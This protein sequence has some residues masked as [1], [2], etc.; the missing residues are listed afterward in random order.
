[1]IGG[2][3]KTQQGLENAMQVGRFEKIN[4]A[5]NVG[6][7]LERV[8]VNDGQVITGPDVFPY[9]DGVAEEFGFGL[10]DAVDRVVPGQVTSRFGERFF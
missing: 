10:L 8:I 3:R 4:P 2:D 7:A 6:D 9:K 1:M 5:H